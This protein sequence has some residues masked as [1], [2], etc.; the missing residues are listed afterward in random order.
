M[1]KEDTI[2]GG[3]YHVKAGEQITCLLSK[4]HFDRAVYGADVKEFNADRMLDENFHHIMNTYP[5]A[6]SPFG[7]GMRSCIGRPFAW[8]EATLALAVLI[9]NFNFV[10]DDPSY[11]LQI[12]ETLTIKP[13]KF[14]VRAIL[15]DGLT[16]SRL[17]ARLAGAFSGAAGAPSSSSGRPLTGHK[18]QNSV[19]SL[20][21]S[22]NGNSAPKMMILYG[23]NAG[24]CQFMAQRLASSASSKGYQASVD[25]LDTAR[26][27][28]PKN[29]PVVIIT[30]SYE[31]EPPHNAAHFV[32]WI[33]TLDADAMKDVS[34]AVYGC[35]MLI[36]K[37]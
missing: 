20:T 18:S 19:V 5:H 7:T 31:G 36:L 6:W 15:R 9:Q 12:Q 30:S 21:N 13:K 33:Q 16:P 10:M 11:S 32:H 8:Q 34:Y 17:E 1:A 28:M 23:S 14:F 24:T 29:T 37:L 4:S 22:V 27:S 25:V 35:G 26:G 3:K 2:I